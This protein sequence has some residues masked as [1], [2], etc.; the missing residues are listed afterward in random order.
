MNINQ[1]LNLLTYTVLLVS[2]VGLLI[3]SL[4]LLVECTAAVFPPVFPKQGY[5]FLD[6][7]VAILIPAH[8]EETVIYTTI[9]DIKLQLTQQHELIVIADNCTDQTA[10][11]ARENSATVIERYDPMRRGKGFA[12]DYG[13]RFLESNPP[14]IVVCFDADCRVEPGA[15]EKLVQYA[16]ATNKPVQAS[17]LI[18]QSSDSS[19]QE[20]VSAFAF[21]VK[22]LVRLLGLSRLGIPCLL[23]GTGMAFPWAAINTIDLA[24]GYIVEDMKLGLDLTIAGYAPVFCSEANVTT[25]LPKKAQAAK[26]QRT[27]WEH[28]HL[29]TLLTYVPRLIEASFKQRRLDLFLSAL[30]LCI[31]PLSLMVIIWLLLMTITIGFGLSTLSWIPTMFLT[32][33]GFLLLSAIM[34]AWT[35][36]G[37]MDLPWQKIVVVPFYIFSKI[38]LYFKFLIQP[39]SIWVRTERD[40]VNTQN[41]LL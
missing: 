15:I 11:I 21:K 39:Q 10:E 14:D 38:S 1:V 6:K 17:Y 13:L 34:I 18:A 12:L 4:M 29:K 33:A 24:S 23:T 40:S 8:N 9:L 5:N 27:R 2:A 19:P 41:D 22:N 7:K 37:F 31:P 20:S 26:S 32:I 25:L 16:I 35:K 3:L 30:D 28:G 36:F